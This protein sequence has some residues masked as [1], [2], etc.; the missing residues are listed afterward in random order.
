[1]WPLLPVKAIASGI[2]DGPHATPTRRVHGP[3]FLG[4]S[5]L[6][7]GRL[8][9]SKSDHVSEADFSKWTRRVTPRA[10]DVVFSYETRIGEA[11][12]IPD[13]LRCCL[14]RR[15]GLIRPDP[16]TVDPRFLIYAYLGPDFQEVLRERTVQGSTVD[17]I[18]LSEF[19]EFP[20][21]VPP[22]PEQRRIAA[23]L[24]A[25]D[26]KIDL[27]RKMNRTL[28]EMAQALFKSWF[29]DFDGQDDL[30]PS[31]LGQIPRGWVDT[32]VGEVI[33]IHDKLRV[34]LSG[35]ERTKR[36]GPYPYHGAASVLDY[37]DDYLF[38]G[39]YI[40]LGE[41][42]SVIDDN[43]RPLIQYVW[44]KFWVN[45]HAHVL[46]P[47]DPVGIEHL[48][49]ALQNANIRPFV[50]GAAQPKVSQNNLKR[51]PFVLPPRDVCQRF[52]DAV[53]PFYSKIRANT[54]Q[55]RTLSELRDLLLP[56]LISGEL[57]IPEAEALIP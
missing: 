9:L 18:L 40:L 31:E 51:I 21:R 4:I 50:T 22:L 16:S 26:D 34:P 7:R 41:D 57:R 44:G 17:R 46:R 30:V 45:N 24:G 28:E 35:L 12:I 8:D 13:G 37:V 52:T 42:G 6:N 11:A 53:A 33:E 29:I 49:V 43:D 56:K 23:V 32:T 36:Q 10:G 3:V 19:P 1:M 14:G 15:M 25:L 27:N 48:L 5:S 54:E 38:D 39:T 2:F 20:I 55:S 47:K